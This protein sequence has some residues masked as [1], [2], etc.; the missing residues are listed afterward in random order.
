MA[1]K[2]QKRINRYYKW[3]TPTIIDNDIEFLQ[4]L[5]TNPYYDEALYVRKGFLSRREWDMKCAISAR[6]RNVQPR[7]ELDLFD[8]DA[9]PK[10]KKK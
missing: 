5:D 10:P 2:E 9:L 3:R 1:K 6:E 7:P 4:Y 8:Y